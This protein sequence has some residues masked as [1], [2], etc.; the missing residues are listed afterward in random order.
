MTAI[1]RGY[2]KFIRRTLTCHLKFE[3]SDD[4]GEVVS[5]RA[6]DKAVIA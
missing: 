3:R 2:A 6:V 4:Y 1:S 5:Q